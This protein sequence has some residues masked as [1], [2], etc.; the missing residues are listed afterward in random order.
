VAK[1]LSINFHTP[2]HFKPD[3]IVKITLIMKKISIS[4]IIIVVSIFGAYRFK[5]LIGVD[6]FE[7]YSL[8]KYFPFKYLQLDSMLYPDSGDIIIAE[9][10]NTSYFFKRNWSNLW[11][12]EKDKVVRDYD[13]NGFHNSRCLLIKSSS[14]KSWA[15]SSLKYIAVKKGDAFS[16]SGFISLQGKNTYAI[17]CL[18]SFDKYKNVINWSYEKTKISQNNKVVK[19]ERKFTITDKIA[20]IKFRIIGRGVGE[21]RFDDIELSKL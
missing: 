13:I 7:S 17:F 8:S 1:L 11:M 19:I 4:I 12:A 21:Y 6:I 3:L 20:F 18:A 14:K 2:G 15:Y 10:F 9:S 16:Y 5:N